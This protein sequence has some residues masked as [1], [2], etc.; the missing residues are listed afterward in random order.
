MRSCEYLKVGGPKRR[1]KLLRLC[2]LRFTKDHRRLDLNSPNLH[3][4]DS[5]AITFEFQK[6]EQRDDTVVQCR[7]GDPLLCPVKAWAAV[8]QRILSYPWGTLDSAVCSYKDHNG[9][10]KLLT[11]AIVRTALRTAARTFGEHRLG[12][13]A[14]E[15]GTH[16]LRSGAAMAMYLAGL[17]SYTIMLIGRWSSNAFLR[18]IRKQVQDFS[19]GVS[20]RMISHDDFFTI[21][22]DE[23]IDPTDPRTAG[24]SYNFSGRGNIVGLAAPS[25]T[26]IPAFALHH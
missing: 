5:V 25:R 13:K 17:P 9:Q 12:F 1:T 16:S 11:D 6:N 26:S 7:S 22:R 15:L 4:A 14:S 3:M 24:N 10:A 2:N 19:N 8:A 21:S 20:R 18:Y 23:V